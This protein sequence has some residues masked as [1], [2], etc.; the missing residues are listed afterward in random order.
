MQRVSTARYLLIANA[1]LVTLCGFQ[2]ILIE[3][4]HRIIPIAPADLVFST[5][6]YFIIKSYRDLNQAK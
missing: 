4:V 6:S 3:G 5:L 1:A 2:T